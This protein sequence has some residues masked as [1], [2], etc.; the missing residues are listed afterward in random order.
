MFTERLLLQGSALA[1][2]AL[3]ALL[4]DLKAAGVL[5]HVED[6]HLAD[7]SAGGGRAHLVLHG[8]HAES[9]DRALDL[10]AARGVAVDRSD[11]QMAVADMDGV[12]PE[13]FHSTTNHTTRVRVG[14]RW[15]ALE[16]LEMDVGI[17]VVQ[18]GGGT[19]ALGCP[20]HKVRRGDVL[21]VG[22]GGVRVLVEA[23]PTTV[24]GS[25]DDAF[26][27]M[28]SEVSGERPKARL[29]EEAAT[30]LR[31]VKAKGQ[32]VLLVGGPAII[33]SGSGPHLEGLIRRGWVDVLFAGN[34]LAAHDV[35]SSMFGTS[36]GVDLGKGSPVRHG[37]THHLRAINRVRRAGGL[38]QAVAQG[39]VKD[40][41]MHACVTRPIP[42]VLCGSIRDDGPLPDVLTDTVQ[43]VDTMRAH[44][45]GVGVA[46]VLATTLH[47]IATGNLLPATV[48]T[49]C[50]DND[51]DTVIKLADRG[52]RQAVGIVTDC[53]Y[54]LATLA[55]HLTDPPGA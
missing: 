52:T 40:G 12:F 43:A 4:A 20:M 53:E 23:A 37:H 21:V 32:K 27:F 44:V 48:K 5:G 22:H 30:T 10:A 47:G 42:F 54:F 36:L 9:L 24:G 11:A 46:L 33:H 19:R 14:G 7:P 6:L 55:R 16:G 1:G 13:G 45:A 35:E 41:V 31:T 38:A 50:V 18:D 15:V 8:P 49:Y 51:A 28:T 29:I 3:A 17:R 34:A 25:D 26:S 2:G 39:L